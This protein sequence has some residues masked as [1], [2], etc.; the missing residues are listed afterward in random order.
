MR[1][2]LLYAGVMETIA[3][4]KLGYPVRELYADF[5][6]RCCKMKW[7]ICVKMT[8]ES[9]PRAGTEAVVSAAIDAGLYI[10]GK[11]KVFGKGDMLKD[12]R[13]WHQSIVV[14]IV[15]KFCVS[16][17]KR[18]QFTIWLNEKMQKLLAAIKPDIE[19]I[20]SIARA[21]P[22]APYALFRITTYSEAMAKAAAAAAETAAAAA[23]QEVADAV[24]AKE[25]AEQEAWELAN[26]EKLVAIRAGDA[27]IAAADGALKYLASLGANIATAITVAVEAAELAAYE[28]R[29]REQRAANAAGDEALTCAQSSAAFAASLLD[30][31]GEAIYEASN[32]E[33]LAAI[34]AGDTALSCVEAMIVFAR[35]LAKHAQEAADIAKMERDQAEF[36]AQQRAAAGVQCLL[37]GQWQ[38]TVLRRRVPASRAIQRKLRWLHTLERMARHRTA[39]TRSVACYRGFTLRKTMF[40]K[41]NAARK[42]NELFERCTIQMQCANWISAM[43]TVC[44][45]DDATTLNMLM[46]RVKPQFSR[47]RAIPLAGLINVRD[48]VAGRSFVHTAGV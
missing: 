47:I 44:M 7:N 40:A 46:T 15:Q 12:I 45:S 32:R 48:R 9:D 39:A 1:R 28:E 29:T 4:R 43:Q 17:L 41:R 14:A 19:K 38:R 35:G 23:V 18:L 33:K 24:A 27:A 6:D 42:I 26:K 16:R 30:A 20:Q 11:T 13:T 22:T 36:L 31:V 5:W 37:R 21:F 10:M 25:K 2:Q 8:A 34:R 3:I